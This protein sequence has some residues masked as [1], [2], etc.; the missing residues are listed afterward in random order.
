MC[1]EWMRA[2]TFPMPIADFHKLPRH[3]AYKYEYFD[4]AAQ[5]T[6]RPRHASLRVG[7]APLLARA[8][9]PCDDGVTLRPVSADDDEPLAHLFAAAFHATQPFASLDDDERLR[10]A[11]ACLDKTRTGGDGPWL[12]RASF[13]AE[14]ERLGRAGAIF[15]TLLP[16]GDPLDA[17][18]LYWPSPVPEALWDTCP[19]QPHLTWV[20]VHPWL[21]QRGVATALLRRAATTLRDAGHAELWSTFLVGNDTS[22]LWHW[23][24]GFELLPSLMSRRR[25]GDESRRGAE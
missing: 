3:P 6:P 10:A 9:A 20:F 8:A 12:R 5:L 7:L 1:D 14:H 16:G 17:D 15:V 4:G 19:G 13:V 2:L 21:R 22:L 25:T 24:N 11:G 23:E 18:S